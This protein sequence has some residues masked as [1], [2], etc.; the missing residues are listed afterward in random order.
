VSNAKIVASDLIPVA[1]LPTILLV[2]K[3]SPGTAQISIW[4]SDAT[5]V[6][7]LPATLDAP[8]VNAGAPN[9]MVLGIGVTCIDKIT[10]W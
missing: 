6:A 2:P 9:S 4:E 1:A 3:F 8:S 5:A 7:A 10:Y